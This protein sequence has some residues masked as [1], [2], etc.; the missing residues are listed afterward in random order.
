MISA[1]QLHKIMPNAGHRVDIF[2]DPL[3]HAMDE[4]EINTIKRQSA[5]LGQIAHESGELRYV[6]EIASGSAYEGRKDLGNDETGDGVKYKGRGLLQITGKYGYEQCGVALG[7]NLVSH[8]EL[9][10]EPENACRSAA[11]WWSKHGCN[12][13]AD[14]E[15]YITITKRINGGM[16]G[17][18]DRVAAYERAQDAIV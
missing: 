1:D 16:N 12:Q 13:L 3:N 4:F 17:Y 5:F 18:A 6:R 10:E 2:L 15:A 7:L 14:A 8:P 9:L 11:W